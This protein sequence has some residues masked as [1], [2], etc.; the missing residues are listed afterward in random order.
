LSQSKRISKDY[1]RLCE[2]SQTMIYAVMSR[3]MLGR[4]ARI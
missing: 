4:L 3:L 2:S 1:E